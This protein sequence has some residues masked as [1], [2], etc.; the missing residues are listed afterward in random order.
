M[1]VDDGTRDGGE[2]DPGVPD[3]AGRNAAGVFWPAATITMVSAASMA[4]E[5]VAGRALAPYVGMSLY[6]WTIIIA[7]VLAGLS[8][9]H[10]IGGRIAD[11]RPRLTRIVAWSLSGAAL[12]SFISLGALQLTAPALDSTDLVP[13]ITALA[14]VA[15]FVPSAFAG[16]LSPLLTVMALK[17]SASE[18]QGAVLGLMFALGA[19]GAILGTVL[20]GLVMISWLG[21][22]GSVGLIGA[23]YALL[24]LRFWRQRAP[25]AAIIA[26]GMLLLVA[27]WPGALG[28]RSACFEESPYFCIRVDDVASFDR[29]ARVMVLDHLVHGVND[30][31][32]PRL[33]MS[34]YVQGV[35]ELV[36]RR[37]PGQSLTAFF[38]GGGA[39]TLPRA[40]QARYPAGRFVIAELDPAVT[41][42]AQDALWYDPGPQTEILHGDARRL[43]QTLPEETR[44]DVIFGDAFHDISIPSHLVTTEFAEL[45]AAR[46]N[47]GG[48]YVLNVVDALRAPRFMLSLAN[49]LALTFPEVELWLDVEALGPTERRTTWIVLASEEPTGEEFL[50]SSY[51]FKR[52]WAR[53]PLEAMVA[54]VG[55]EK[56][57]VLTDDYAPVDR[58]LASV[59]LS[60]EMDR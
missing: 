13:H 22:A 56:L 44:F 34:P 54:A 18:R 1:G 5:I 31:A 2:G 50:A 26:A 33:L 16:V 57:A 51:G 24:S 10:W 46:L 58:L 20:S 47:P 37:M 3:G 49:T 55:E 8:L 53:V 41:K 36:A 32:D 7:V 45:V 17:A 4:L 39:F 9:G 59:L 21:T 38:V 15:F 27:A 23:I 28:L 35:D 43:L 30:R 42:V 48:L 14:M 19:L 40:W 25:Q 11:R 52:E 6:T 29:P 60:A 12:T